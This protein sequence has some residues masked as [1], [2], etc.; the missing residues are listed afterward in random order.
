MEIGTRR[1][2]RS[3]I[4]GGLNYAFYHLALTENNDEQ[5]A[6]FRVKRAPQRTL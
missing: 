5:S 6:S 2:G 3:A 1:S 4:Y